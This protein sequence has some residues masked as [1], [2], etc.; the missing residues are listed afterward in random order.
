MINLLSL[1]KLELGVFSGDPMK[2]HT[3]I[4]AFDTNVDKLS[5]NPD[6]KIA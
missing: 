6:G 1:P 3:F 4:R 2:Y 5:E